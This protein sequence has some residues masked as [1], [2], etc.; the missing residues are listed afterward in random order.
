[1]NNIMWNNPLLPV[2]DRLEIAI[3]GIDFRDKVID[4]L[5]KQI[6]ALRMITDAHCEPRF[7]EAIQYIHLKDKNES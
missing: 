6:A 7:V 3:G 5:R 4:N 1:M 2:E